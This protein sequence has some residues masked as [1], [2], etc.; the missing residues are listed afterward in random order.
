MSRI[1]LCAIAI[2]AATLVY[3]SC[4]DKSEA[5]VTVRW[6]ES[7]V[8]CWHYSVTYH[9][10]GTLHLNDL[11]RLQQQINWCTDDPPVTTVFSGPSSIRSYWTNL[12]W[13]FGG[14]ITRSVE[15]LYFPE[16]WQFYVKAKFDGNGAY[17]LTE[18][19]YPWVRMTI[20]KWNPTHVSY[21]VGCGC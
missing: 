7:S 13:N 11:W 17:L 8:D 1:L 21:T 3:L 18:H 9:R 19:N 15:H 20:W 5:S 10:G 14:Y 6:S 16:R 12:T 4:S 2:L